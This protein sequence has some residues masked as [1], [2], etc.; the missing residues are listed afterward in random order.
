MNGDA[1][2][3]IQ[4]SYYREN[5]KL[6]PTGYPYGA[7][8]RW[9]LLCVFSSAVRQQ[10]P[11]V[12]LGNSATEFLR[13]LGMPR[14]GRRMRAV[15]DQLSRLFSAS[16]RFSFRNRQLITGSNLSVASD[17]MLWRHDSGT[18]AHGYVVLSESVFNDLIQH[19][20]PLDSGAVRALRDSPLA[21]DLFVFLSFR[22][23][24]QIQPLKLSWVALQKQVGADFTE[25][26]EFSRYARRA[27]RRVH[28]V[29]PSLK[30]EFF[31]GGVT[32]FPPTQL[33]VKMQ[34]Y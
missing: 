31:R 28:S 21:I 2:L 18:R 13:E 1:A 34:K 6:K 32:F 3:T 17:F 27:M 8:A 30:T 9:L 15:N 16:I 14:D 26:K 5:G 4:Q 23:R 10:A 19:P 7:T 20:I 25:T 33:P 24:S 22:L 11:V 12:S 29:W